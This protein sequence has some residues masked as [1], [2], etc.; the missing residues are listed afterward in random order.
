MASASN[1]GLESEAESSVRVQ[2]KDRHLQQDAFSCR[3]NPP[4]S[5]QDLGNHTSDTPE[6]TTV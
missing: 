3:D 4:W 5:P 6:D 2:E 1:S